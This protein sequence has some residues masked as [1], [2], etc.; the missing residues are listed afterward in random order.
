MLAEGLLPELPGCFQSDGFESHVTN[1]T[2]KERRNKYG[3]SVGLATPD[4]A[5]P[6]RFQSSFHVKGRSK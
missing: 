1:V 4:K 6:Q 2:P 3:V 5:S